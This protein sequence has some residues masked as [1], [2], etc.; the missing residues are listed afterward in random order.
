MDEKDAR[1]LD[2]T[3]RLLKDKSNEKEIVQSLMDIGI[4]ESKAKDMLEL[5][6]QERAET[7]PGTGSFWDS[8]SREFFS[9]RNAGQK[10]GFELP[11]FSAKGGV[12]G[13]AFLSEQAPRKKEYK[14]VGFKEE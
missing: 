13:G 1:L 7:K 3:R 9:G 12:A 2:A 6:K 14:P 8:E 10:A 5:A 4:T 11:G